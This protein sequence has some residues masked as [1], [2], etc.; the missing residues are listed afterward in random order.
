[1]IYVSSFSVGNSDAGRKY[2]SGFLGSEVM[3]AIGENGSG[4]QKLFWTKFPDDFM[5]MRKRSAI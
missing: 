4:F 1:V 5:A 3:K 2:R